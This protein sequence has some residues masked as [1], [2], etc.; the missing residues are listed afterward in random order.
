M[1]VGGLAGPEAILTEIGVVAFETFV[2]E[3]GEIGR[4]AAA[5]DGWMDDEF[6]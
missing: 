1:R 4:T 6:D 5:A 3:P 2:A